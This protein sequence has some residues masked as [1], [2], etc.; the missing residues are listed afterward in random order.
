MQANSGLCS[1][2]QEL[3]AQDVIDDFLLNLAICNTVVPATCPLGGLQYQ[4]YL[5]LKDAPK[6]IGAKDCCVD[7]NYNKKSEVIELLFE[8]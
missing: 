6:L 4:V 8:Q 7:C 1:C 3:K 5:D 2:L